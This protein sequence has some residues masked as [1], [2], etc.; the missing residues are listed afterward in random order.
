MQQDIYSLNQSIA[1]IKEGGEAIPCE[2][3]FASQ[4]YIQ[5]VL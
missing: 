2:N 3:L 5:A 4:G 1:H